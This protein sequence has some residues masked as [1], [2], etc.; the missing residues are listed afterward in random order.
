MS[1]IGKKKVECKIQSQN[2][3]SNKFSIE[4]NQLET[5]EENKFWLTRHLE[6]CRQI[7]LRDFRIITVN[8]FRMSRK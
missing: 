2:F 6:M 5:R 7:F 1:K 8:I 4:G 3:L